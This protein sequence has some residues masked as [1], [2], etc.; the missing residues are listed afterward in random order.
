M[1]C[2][3]DRTC[4]KFNLLVINTWMRSVYLYLQ[5]A[6]DM[7]EI[8]WELT[9]QCEDISFMRGCVFDQN[10]RLFIHGCKHHLPTS[11]F[12]ISLELPIRIWAGFFPSEG[13]T[14][15]HNVS[16]FS[17]NLGEIWV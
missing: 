5:N 10:L 16:H 1:T 8:G 9:T 11:F 3:G 4:Y 13:M 17:S 15:P 6:K 7:K 14:R 2:L 12:L